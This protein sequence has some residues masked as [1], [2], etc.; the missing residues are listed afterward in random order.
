[1][2]SRRAA[3]PLV[4]GRRR[5]GRAA[6]KCSPV[7]AQWR[8]YG[9]YGPRR[10]HRARTP[11]RA[12]SSLQQTQATSVTQMIKCGHTGMTPIWG[13]RLSVQVAR[14]HRDRCPPTPLLRPTVRRPCQQWAP[15]GPPATSTLLP[16]LVGRQNHRAVHQYVERIARPDRQRRLDAQILVEQIGADIVHLLSQG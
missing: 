11:H 9:R 8:G 10:C 2:Q 4:P 1:M 15:C 5:P 16:H 13:T 6:L 12:K 7:R 14:V 3:V